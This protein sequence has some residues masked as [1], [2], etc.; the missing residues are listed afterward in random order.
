MKILITGGLGHIGSYFLE[1]IKK[2]KSIKKIY[3]IDNFETNRYATLFNL[4]A[5]KS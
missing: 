2:I 5:A 1:N 3:L 4:T